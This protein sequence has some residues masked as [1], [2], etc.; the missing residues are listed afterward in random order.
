[1]A[2]SESMPTLK[3][4][5]ARQAGLVACR[6]CHTLSTPVKKLEKNEV[7]RCSCCGSRL[8]SR[9][10][11]SLSKTW[12]LL[13]AATALYIPANLL[14]IMTVIFQGNGEP[15]TIMQGVFHLMEGGMWPLALIVFIASIFVPVMK[16]VI[17]AGLLLSIS[18]HSQWSP[19][20][21]V[22]W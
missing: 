7:P 17:L 21:L 6:F 22:I 14:P 2:T 5:T 10:P 20:E 15:S 8:H 9:I 19:K 16:L 3:L 1:M 4:Q 12:A 18:F 13:L 11:G